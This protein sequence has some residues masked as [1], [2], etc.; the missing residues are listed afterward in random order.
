MGTKGPVGTGT[1]FAYRPQGQRGS[2]SSSSKDPTSD[3]TVHTPKKTT[4]PQHSH[5]TWNEALR[6]TVLKLFIQREGSEHLLS[7]VTGYSVRI[8][9]NEREFV[10]RYRLSIWGN[11]FSFGYDFQRQKQEVTQVKLTSLVLQNK[12]N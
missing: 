12:L 4:N 1:W 7:V 11:Y 3:T 8:F 6:H 2:S 10:S 9:L 5:Q